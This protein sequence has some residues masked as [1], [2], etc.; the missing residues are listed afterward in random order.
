MLLLVAISGRMITMHDNLNDRRAVVAKTLEPHLSAD[1]LDLSLEIYDADFA[2]SDEFSSDEFCICLNTLLSETRLSQESYS[3]LLVDLRPLS[4]STEHTAVTVEDS[5]A[6]VTDRDASDRRT[7]P[8]NP[9]SQ[10][11][12]RPHPHRP[13]SRHEPRTPVLLMGTYQHQGQSDRTPVVIEDLSRSG[14][15]MLSFA[16]DALSPGD[17]VD[18]QFG[19]EDSDQSVIKTTVCVRWVQRDILGAQIVHP[20][21]L[22]QAFFD[23][24]QVSAKDGLPK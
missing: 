16:P 9:F 4:S 22:P 24:L 8:D 5:A 19:L 1:D 21:A 6:G 17:I 15:G 14:V 11:Q 13:E 7:D 3:S 18:L 23:F 2:T 10:A 20:E 12:F